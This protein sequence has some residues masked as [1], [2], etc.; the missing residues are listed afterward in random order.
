MEIQS[1]KQERNKKVQK[2]SDK[3]LIGKKSSKKI[4]YRERNIRMR[5]T[6]HEH[7]QSH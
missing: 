1:T 5:R 3:K 2:S 4:N 7:N 6:S